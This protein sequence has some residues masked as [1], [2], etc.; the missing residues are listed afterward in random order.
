[1]HLVVS[2]LAPTVSLVS[3]RATLPPNGKI[4]QAGYRMS[5]S[6]PGL[7]LCATLT[8]Q[9]LVWSFLATHFL[10]DS[11]TR[12][13]CCLAQLIHLMSDTMSLPMSVMS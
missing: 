9:S 8:V 13:L 11:L 3:T 6:A 12:S 5:V 4:R 1:M 2:F 10:V 7:A